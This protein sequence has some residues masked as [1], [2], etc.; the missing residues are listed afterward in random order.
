M[1]KFLIFCRIQLKFRFRLY[2]K[3]VHTFWKF[4][5]EKTS[6]K[7]ISPKSLWQTYMKWAVTTTQPLNTVRYRQT[8]S[9]SLLSQK[10]SRRALLQQKPK[11]RYTIHFMTDNHATSHYCQIS[12]RE[13]WRSNS[14]PSL[15]KQ[16][17]SVQINIQLIPTVEKKWKDQVQVYNTV[18]YRHLATVIKVIKQTDATTEDHDH[19]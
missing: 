13:D 16:Y 7:K 6:K 8:H 18:Y 4:Q 10:W 12:D 3:R 2:K 19:L 17:Y 9:C 14:R 5:L 15:G 1:G 11:F